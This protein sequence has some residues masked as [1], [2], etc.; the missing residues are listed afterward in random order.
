MQFRKLAFALPAVLTLVTLASHAQAG[1]LTINASF[2]S[3]V[4]G[5]A[6]SAAFEAAVNAAIS[7]TLSY[8]DTSSVVNETIS[9]SETPG[10]GLGGSSAYGPDVTYSQYYNFLQNR[11]NPTPI[12]ATALAS[13]PI[14]DGTGGTGI[15]N[16]ATNIRVVPGLA[17]AIG[18][19][20][21]ATQYI[22][23][24]NGVIGNIGINTSITNDSRTGNLNTSYYDLQSVVQHEIDELLGVGGQGTSLTD[25]GS[26][27]DVGILDLFRY[28]SS[29]IRS[30]TN[31]TSASSYFS[32]NG[33]VTNLDSFN[34]TGGGADYADWGS[35]SVAQVQDAFGSPDTQLNLGSAELMSFDVAGYQLTSAGKALEIGSA[36]SAPEPSSLLLLLPGALTLGG[37]VI[38]RRKT[39]V[40]GRVSPPRG[41]LASDV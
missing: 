21:L 6:D 14:P 15:N 30:Y 35:S 12:E 37:L 34:Q 39:A 1:N 23:L 24:Y 27:T 25:G 26:A 41:F 29:G 2:D 5:A 3:S 33:G 17:N 31:S 8:V 38:R 20:A 32:I 10:Q 16:D 40:K 9:F 4:T 28:S 18:Q 36:A 13:M 11:L 22:N 19:T 7:Q